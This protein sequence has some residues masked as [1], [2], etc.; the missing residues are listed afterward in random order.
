MF[1]KLKSLGK[2]KPKQQP[3]EY[4][5][6]GNDYLDEM[7]DMQNNLNQDEFDYQHREIDGRSS[8]TSRSDKPKRTKKPK[9]KTAKR[10]NLKKYQPMAP[11]NQARHIIA[12]KITLC[13]H[14]L[15]WARDVYWL[16]YKKKG[17]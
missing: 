6:Q 10:F 17:S 13:K 1:E 4:F 7:E 3:E 12:I 11:A 5:A 2:K 15:A 8:R 16:A 14:N 9:E